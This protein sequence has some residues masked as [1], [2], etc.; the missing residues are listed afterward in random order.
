M[1]TL[2]A[3][4]TT[5]GA[6]VSGASVIVGG[7]DVLAKITPSTKDDEAIDAAKRGLSF[8]SAVLDK[9]SIWNWQKK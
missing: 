3:I 4:F 5:V 7:L 1:E 2:Y 8:V 6:V 9:V